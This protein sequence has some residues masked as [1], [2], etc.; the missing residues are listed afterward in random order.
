MSRLNSRSTSSEPFSSSLHHHEEQELNE[1]VLQ[2]DNHHN[3]SPQAL[4]T[5]PA[6]FNFDFPT[7]NHDGSVPDLT[8]HQSQA[9][10]VTPP[11]ALS[12]RGARANMAYTASESGHSISDSQYDMLDDLSEISNDDHDTVSSVG[13]SGR[14]ATPE[15]SDT[16]NDIQVEEDKLTAHLPTHHAEVELPSLDD[17]ISSPATGESFV[18]VHQP[19]KLQQLRAENDLIDSYMSEDLE[20]PRQSTMPFAASAPGQSVASFPPSKTTTQASTSTS[21]YSLFKTLMLIVSVLLLVPIAMVEWQN[22]FWNLA[23]RR[24]ALLSS[25]QTATGSPIVPGSVNIQHLLPRAPAICHAAVLDS[26]LSDDKCARLPRFDVVLPNHFVLSLPSSLTYPDLVSHEVMKAG[27]PVQS[28]ITQLIPGV[29]LMTFDEMEAH[30]WVAFKAITKRPP[31]DVYA[32]HNFGRK[33]V[34]Q[35][36]SEVSK[37]VGKE[38]AVMRSVH[39]VL[40][41]KLSTGFGKGASATQNITTELAKY[42]SRELAVVGSSAVVVF[43]EA[44]GAALD[45]AASLNKGM[46]KYAA[47]LSKSMEAKNSE[48]KALAKNPLVQIRD[49][50]RGIKKALQE[51]KDRRLN[52]RL[53]S[54]KNDFAKSK[55]LVQHHAQEI[56]TSSRS[57]QK[58]LQESVRGDARQHAE[59]KKLHRLKKNA[60]K[61]EKALKKM[62]EEREAKLHR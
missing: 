52:E 10:Y 32:S 56:L 46:I 43:Q 20:T 38:L 31:Y 2:L 29:Y 15:L 37:T 58:K 24:D 3:F 33:S 62:K 27:K 17:E 5:H 7:L 45:A 51:G 41:S 8:S 59:E 35:T 40:G 30:S 39:N 12:S 21:Y 26:S 23:S 61:L 13:S 4:P 54:L 19:S 50:M 49:R 11:A 53:T 34:Q 48:T 16:E 14:P 57:L 1:S 28:N 9:S 44:T 25:L 22:S 60:A 6:S 36:S 55:Q 18:N 47:D 42:M